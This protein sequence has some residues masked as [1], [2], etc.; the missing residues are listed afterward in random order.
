[1]CYLNTT[2]ESFQ[3]FHNKVKKHVQ[4]P[5]KK[6]PESSDMSSH[7]LWIWLSRTQARKGTDI[8]ADVVGFQNYI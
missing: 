3:N 4:E 6:T 8:M 5:E 7:R 1:M 2:H